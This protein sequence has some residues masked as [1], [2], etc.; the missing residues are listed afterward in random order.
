MIKYYYIIITKL[1]HSHDGECQSGSDWQNVRVD[2]RMH[3][4]RQN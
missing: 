1:T 3:R 2:M 4:L